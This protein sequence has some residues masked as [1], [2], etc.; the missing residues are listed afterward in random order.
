M[1][2]VLFEFV[3][4][5]HQRLILQVLDKVAVVLDLDELGD[6]HDLVLDDFLRNLNLWLGLSRFVDETSQKFFVV[7]FDGDLLLFLLGN[8]LG[9]DGGGAVGLGTA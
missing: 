4:L 3:G 2:R 1:E 9:E 5:D 7:L 8:S 6:F